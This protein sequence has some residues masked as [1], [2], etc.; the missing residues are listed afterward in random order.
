M[1]VNDTHQVTFQPGDIVCEGVPHGANLLRVALLEGV[2][3]NA[4]CGGT[5]A[6]GKCRVKISDGRY[7]GG[8]SA[9]LSEE[10]YAAGLRLACRVTVLG[11]SDGAHSGGIAHG[12]RG[13]ADARAAAGP[14]PGAYAAGS[15]EPGE[16]LE[17]RP[18]GQARGAPARAAGCGQ[19]HRRSR[20]PQAG[21]EKPARHRG[22]VGRL[23]C[24]SRH[25]RNAAGER[26]V[27][28]GHCRR[29]GPKDQRSY[30]W[31]LATGPTT[32][33]RSCSTSARPASTRSCST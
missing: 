9:K 7:E 31:S 4:S 11:R 25:A 6:C 14:G 15:R 1:S 3:I 8:S 16:R 24:N 17:R 27:D 19:Q 10:E 28:H 21:A 32:I 26:L 23:P 22:S 18:R 12:R 5:G 2:H 29:D 13:G 33:I 30:R 20:P